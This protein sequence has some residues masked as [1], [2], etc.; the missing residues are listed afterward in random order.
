M[1][2]VRQLND[3]GER[4]LP[5]ALL[6]FSRFLGPLRLAL[7]LA[8]SHRA[9][10]FRAALDPPPLGLL[11]ALL[12]LG[13]LDDG[14][15]H[16]P[17]RDLV[18]AVLL[19]IALALDIVHPLDRGQSAQAFDLGLKATGALFGSGKANNPVRIFA[20]GKIGHEASLRY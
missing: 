13:I 16:P 14:L 4:V 8:I 1:L 7:F 6:L 12:L 3:G 19:G 10:L 15:D 5:F 20:L 17:E 11:V 2:A 18:D 9:L